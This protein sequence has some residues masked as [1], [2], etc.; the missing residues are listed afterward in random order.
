[1]GYGEDVQSVSETSQYVVSEE[2]ET[3]SWHEI[4]SMELV[5]AE[6]VADN[7]EEMGHEQRNEDKEEEQKLIIVSSGSTICYEGSHRQGCNMS[8]VVSLAE[9]AGL[10]LMRRYFITLQAALK[11]D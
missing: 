1:M 5:S 6:E 9:V 8:Y 3:G 4:G 7:H 10:I 2:E 11:N